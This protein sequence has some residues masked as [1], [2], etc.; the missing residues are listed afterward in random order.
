MGDAVGGEEFGDGGGAALVPDFFEPAFCD[1]DVGFGRLASLF[2]GMGM[3]SL[4]VDD[5]EVYLGLSGGVTSWRGA[6]QSKS[7]ARGKFR[8]EP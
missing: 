8:K 6:G 3:V 2:C 7:K 1:G 4:G 5:G